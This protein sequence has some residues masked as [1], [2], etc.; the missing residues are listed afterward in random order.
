MVRDD[1]IGIATVS[2]AKA[3][4]A[5]SDQ[6]QVPVLSKKSKKQHGFLSL[7]LKWT[8]NSALRPAAPLQ[9]QPQPVYY[10]PPPPPQQPQAPAPLF[11]PQM[12][13][14]APPPGTVQDPYYPTAAPHVG[15][16][17]HPQGGAP[18][19]GGAPPPGAAAPL[20]PQGAYPHHGG[21]GA[22]PAPPRY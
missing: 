19:A 14:N 7:T 18:A 21:Y 15:G 11:Y 5:G 1:T 13:A 2:L 9:P 6:L 10:A 12:Y 17:P 22:Y 3:R 4:E 8:P 16:Y 20:P